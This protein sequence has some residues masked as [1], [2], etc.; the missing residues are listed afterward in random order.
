[1]KVVIIIPTYNEKGNIEKL[2]TTLEEEIFPQIKNHDMSILVADDN[3]PDG[4]AN[5]VKKLMKQFK[6][7]HLNSGERKGLGAAYIRAMNYAIEKLSAQA[8]FEMDADLSHDPKKVPVFLKKFD[9]GFDMVVGTRY[10]EGGSIPSNWPLQRKLFSIVGNLTVRIILMRFRIH[11]WT[12]GFRVLKKEVFL[13]EKEELTNFK[14][15]TFQVSFLHKVSRDGFKIGEVPINF[16]DRTLGRSKIA[17]KEYIIDLLTYVILARIKEILF[18]KF[19]K[20][21][22]VGGLG[23]IIN[24]TVLRVLVEG[25][26][27]DPSY[28]NLAGAALAIFSNFNF[29]NLWTFRHRRITSLGLYFW[30]MLHFYATSSFG[31]V[32][33]QTGTIFILSRL[34][35]KENYFIYFL[36]GTFFLL[37][38]NFTVYNRFIWK[39]K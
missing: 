21:L 35:G 34:L 14:G 17:P 27:W 4:T 23:F 6:N 25:F 30:K 10:S 32:F 24:A 8:M 16:T 18:G 31:V 20:F 36:I 3:S 13:K 19:G 22:V 26:S 38:W 7:L 9:E 15:Y 12:G 5:E 28:A 11:D 1:M 33:I 37:I 39:E 29:N 2:I